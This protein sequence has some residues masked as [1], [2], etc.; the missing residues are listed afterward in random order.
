MPLPDQDRE[1]KGPQIVS[2]LLPLPPNTRTAGRYHHGSLT[3]LFS[4]PL[5]FLWGK[6]LCMSQELTNVESSREPLS[7]LSE[8]EGMLNGSL[9]GCCI[10]SWTS[11]Y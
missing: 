1:D 6:L 5:I 9:G 4:L 8:T 7:D 3:S 11:L 2:I 10:Y